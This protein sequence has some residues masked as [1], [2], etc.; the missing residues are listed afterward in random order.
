LPA[1]LLEEGDLGAF[2]PIERRIAE[3]GQHNLVPEGRELGPADRTDAGPRR[4][5]YFERPL[6]FD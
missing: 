4:T 5:G 2:D 3:R 6:P 1:A